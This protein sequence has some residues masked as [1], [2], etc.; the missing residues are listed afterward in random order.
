MFVPRW[1]QQSCYDAVWNEIDRSDTVAQLPTGSGKSHVLGM[2]ATTI[3]RDYGARV[4]ILAHVKELLEQ[5]RKA[6]LTQWPTAPTSFWCAGLRQ[7]RAR[8]VTFGSIQSIYA[9]T[10]RTGTYDVIEIDEAHLIPHKKSGMYRSFIAAQRELNPELRVVGVTATPFRTQSGLLHEGEDRLFDSL[11]Y[12]QKIT[13]LVAEGYLSPLVGKHAESSVDMSDAKIR[14]GEFTSESEEQKFTVDRMV[15]EAV[16]ELL[17]ESDTR[18]SILVFGSTV[19]HAEQI[20]SEIMHQSGERV[21]LTTGKTSAAERAQSAIDFINGRSRYMVNVGVYTTGFDAPGIDCIGLM[22]ATKSPGLYAQIAG[23]GL[24]ISPATGKINCLLLDFGG[25]IRR[26]GILDDI[27]SDVSGREVSELIQRSKLCPSCGYEVSK[28]ATV[29]SHC[30]TEI[31]PVAR[32]IIHDTRADTV[33]PMNAPPPQWLDVWRV[34][35]YLHKKE[36]KPPSMRVAYH[37][38]HWMDGETISEW[39]C[40]EH[41]GWAQTKAGQ[42]ATRH[43]VSPTPETVEAALKIDWREP[44]R[45][46]AKKDGK[47]YRI[48]DYEF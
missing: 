20:Q 45:I 13:P 18:N 27:T 29:C 6:L 37:T 36:G 34:G 43:G 41:Q 32:E 48:T 44:K 33:D 46:L 15:A 40:F 47:F 8:Q 25:N 42:W 3:A 21:L 22:R 26:H 1:Y 30:G 24:R 9:A 5:N 4:L 31:K 11:C 28:L 7:K 38:G 35:Y 17:A 16:E 39:V 2:L 23:R 14:A 19:K 10:K 12:E